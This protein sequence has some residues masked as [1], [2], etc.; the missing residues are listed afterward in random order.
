MCGRPLSATASAAEVSTSLVVHEAKTMV[1]LSKAMDNHTYRFDGVFGQHATN[2]QIFD[3]ALGPMVRALVVAASLTSGYV[4]RA[5]VPFC[6]HA[7]R[8]P[9]RWRVAT[10]LFSTRRRASP[11]AA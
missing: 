1:D 5:G 9:E 10:R 11:S 8:L 4:T 2:A 3:V 6:G 7:R